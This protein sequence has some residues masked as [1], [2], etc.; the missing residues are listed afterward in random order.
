AIRWE[1]LMWDKSI[2]K[3][4]AKIS[5]YISTMI[6]VV[7]LLRALIFPVEGSASEIAIRVL[8]LAVSMPAAFWVFFVGYLFFNPNIDGHLDRNGG[9]KYGAQRNS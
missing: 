7:I 1:N 4:A 2:P 3:R 9:G 6:F 8:V 5:A